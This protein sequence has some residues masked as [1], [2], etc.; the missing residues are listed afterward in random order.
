[1][2]KES[3]LKKI[4]TPLM[5]TDNYKEVEIARKQIMALFRESENEQPKPI[6]S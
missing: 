5:G 2:D 4:L 6:D 1:M 3:Q